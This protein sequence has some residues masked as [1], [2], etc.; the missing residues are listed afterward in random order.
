MTA[1]FVMMA[2]VVLLRLPATR[3]GCCKGWTPQ[4]PVSSGVRM[5]MDVPTV[6]VDVPTVAVDV[7]TVAVD[8]RV[9]HDPILN[10]RHDES[11]LCETWSRTWSRLVKNN[12]ATRGNRT[13][14]LETRSSSRFYRP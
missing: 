11:G 10:D 4:M 6:A 14:A 8:V 9:A 2:A 13:S 5:T 7:P 3:H 12:R 1:A